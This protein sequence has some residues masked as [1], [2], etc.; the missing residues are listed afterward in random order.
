[1]IFIRMDMELFFSSN[2]F[3]D[4]LMKKEAST[5]ILP[6]HNLLKTSVTL[7]PVSIIK[8]NSGRI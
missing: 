5:D 7:T 6:Q 4:F 8:I 3:P 2:I 1:M